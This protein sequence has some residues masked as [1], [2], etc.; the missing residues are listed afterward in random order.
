MEGWLVASEGLGLLP[1][2]RGGGTLAQCCATGGRVVLPL[3]RA[4]AVSTS[5][6]VRQRIAQPHRVRVGPEQRA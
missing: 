1:R 3:P 2:T 4:A 6:R 5:L